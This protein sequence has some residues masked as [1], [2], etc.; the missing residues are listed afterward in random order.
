MRNSLVILEQGFPV[1][2]D[3]NLRKVNALRRANSTVGISET[4]VPILDESQ[5]QFVAEEVMDGKP[6]SCYHCTIWN[7]AAHTCGLFGPR[8]PV[9]KFIYPETATEDSQ[10]IEYWPVC[11][12]AQPGEPN[13]GEAKYRPFPYLDPS[14]AGLCWVNAPKIGL[15]YGGATCGGA[16]QGDDCDYFLVEDGKAKW[17]CASGLCRVM[18]KTVGSGDV[19]AAFTDDDLLDWQKGVEILRSQHA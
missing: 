7:Q 11:G 19:C 6:C 4:S 3:K 5:V 18:Q 2:S 10:R 16:N 13:T 8:I 9:Q 17:D 14:Q 12:A 15:E 1:Y